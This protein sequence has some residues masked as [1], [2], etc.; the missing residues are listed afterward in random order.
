MYTVLFKYLVKPNAKWTPGND[1]GQKSFKSEQEANEWV[2][3]QA[4]G[5]KIKPIKLFVWDETIQCN[6][7]IKVF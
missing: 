6:S 2:K 7:T 4:K 3:A 5:D 1:L